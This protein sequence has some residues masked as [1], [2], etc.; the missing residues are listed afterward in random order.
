MKGGYGIICFI[1]LSAI[2]VGLLSDICYDH[3]RQSWPLS[4]FGTIS[5]TLANF[6]NIIHIFISYDPASTHF[7]PT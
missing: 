6:T 1:P 2:P 3:R 4:H 7:Q 5:K